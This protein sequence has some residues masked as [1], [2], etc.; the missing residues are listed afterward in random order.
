MKG[1]KYIEQKQRVRWWRVGIGEQTKK[2]VPR[3]QPQPQPQ[4]HLPSC[5]LCDEPCHERRHIDQRHPDLRHAVPLP[6]RH[7]LVLHRLEVHRHAER[8]AQLIHARVPP[9]EGRPACV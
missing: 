5:L 9:P 3:P 7:A 4:P 6:E 1:Y 8:G 2:V